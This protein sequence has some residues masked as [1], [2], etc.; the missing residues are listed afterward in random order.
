MAYVCIDERE[1]EE[2]VVVVSMSPSILDCLK[3]PETVE[4]RGE[5]IT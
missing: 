3:V 2:H 4:V 1:T 5:V